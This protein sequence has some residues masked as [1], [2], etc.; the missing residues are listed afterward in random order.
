M[1][2]IK[3]IICLF[4]IIHLIVNQ[5]TN[6]AIQAFALRCGVILNELPFSFWYKKV[7]SII[8]LFVVS[9]GS[10]LL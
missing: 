3:K 6:K 8:C 4:L 9:G 5:I 7:D 1:I 2:L 10:F